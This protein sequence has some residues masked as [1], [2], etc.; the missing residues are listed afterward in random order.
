MQVPLMIIF[1][2]GVMGI[3]SEYGSYVN[4]HPRPYERCE[5]TDL[6]RLS[7]C[8][9]EVLSK[10]DDCKS[11]DLACECCALQLINK[12]C[13]GLCP[14]NRSNNFLYQ[15]YNDCKSLND[16]NACSLPFKKFDELPKK[17]NPET[18]VEENSVIVKSKLSSSKVSGE[19]LVA[20]S[21]ENHDPLISEEVTSTSQTPGDVFHLQSQHAIELD[22]RLNNNV[23]FNN[24]S[25]DATTSSSKKLNI[26]ISCAVGLLM[27]LIT[28]LEL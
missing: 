28:N 24:S 12:E 3:L 23:S 11:N 5:A 15:L 27:I 9:N 8:C 25:M 16:I 19:Q 18:M 21:L 10:L 13:Y 20:E 14:G 7:S 2:E 6:I 1:I 4:P 22:P 17:F 26:Y